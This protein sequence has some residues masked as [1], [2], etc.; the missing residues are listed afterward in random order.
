MKLKPKFTYQRN[1]MKADP[2]IILRI[3]LK[4]I[5]AHYIM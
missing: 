3:Y 1:E 5:Q 4:K 2:E